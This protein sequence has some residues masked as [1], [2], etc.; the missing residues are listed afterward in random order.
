MER[1]H[2][3]SVSSSP[4]EERNKSR[5]PVPNRGGERFGG[6]DMIVWPWLCFLPKMMRML[7]LG[8]AMLGLYE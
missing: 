5:E 1:P 8:A 7:S 2:C 4:G 3:Y 6:V